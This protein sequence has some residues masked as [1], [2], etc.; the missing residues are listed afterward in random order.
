MIYSQIDLHIR[1]LYVTKCPNGVYLF[2]VFKIYYEKY[3]CLVVLVI[4]AGA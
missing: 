1:N 3:R 4:Y 2:G